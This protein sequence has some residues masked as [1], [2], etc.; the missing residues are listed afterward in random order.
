M[1]ETPASFYQQRAP[2]PGANGNTSITELITLFI[3]KE[4]VKKKDKSKL[5]T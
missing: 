1:S 3:C 2:F 4:V 5:G